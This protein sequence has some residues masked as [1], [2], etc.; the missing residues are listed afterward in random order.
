MTKKTGLIIKMSTERTSLRCRQLRTRSP[1]SFHSVRPQFRC[2]GFWLFK[3]LAFRFSICYSQKTKYE[4]L[5]HAFK[6]FACFWLH[7]RTRF[8]TPSVR[9]FAVLDFGCSKLL[10][11]VSQFAIRKLFHFSEFFTWSCWVQL[12][13]VQFHTAH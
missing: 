11:S 1:D 8:R 6:P 9:N 5:L 4:L 13:F 3:T 12:N 7:Q 10:H 2:L